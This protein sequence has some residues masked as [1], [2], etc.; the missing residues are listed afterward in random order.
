MAPEKNKNILIIDNEAPVRNVLQKM[1]VNN[2]YLAAQVSNSTEGLALLQSDTFDLVITELIM[3]DPDGFETMREIKTRKP[4]I[5]V[6]AMS[7]HF[8]H[9]PEDYKEVL[10]SCGA[11]EVLKKP[12]D[13]EEM[14]ERIE[15]LLR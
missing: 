10:K 9:D 15:E 11:D 12:V 4:D 7:G 8:E 1:L 14:V 13:T 5:K 3:P 6:I 2:G